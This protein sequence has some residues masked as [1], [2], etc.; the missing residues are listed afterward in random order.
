MREALR[1]A[2]EASRLGEVPVGAVVVHEGQVVGRGWNQTELLQDATA[3]AELLAL[4]A[5]SAALAGWRLEGCTLYTTLE[6]CCMCAGA[7]FLTRISKVVWAAPDLRLGA[8]GSFVDLFALA[9]PMHRPEI[10]SGLCADQSSALLRNFFQGRR[11]DN[12]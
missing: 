6:P 11:H 3:H 9:H 7:I 1:E 2:K 10:L 12:D 4:G 8:N 5:A